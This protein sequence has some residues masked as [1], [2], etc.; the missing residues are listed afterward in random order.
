MEFHF[1]ATIRV[2]FCCIPKFKNFKHMKKLI[3]LASL[4]LLI[5][6]GKSMA[7]QAD[8]FSYDAV[9]IENQMA[10]LDQL[11]RYVLENPGI[12]LS[13]MAIVGNSLAGMV[14]DRTVLVG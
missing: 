2:H 13:Q 1:L 9:T 4:L 8:L 10:Q 7:G 3:I 14:G 6:V 12:T 11:E 5:S